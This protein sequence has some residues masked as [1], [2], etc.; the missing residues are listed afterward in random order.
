MVCPSPPFAWR[1]KGHTGP[2]FGSGKSSPTP[3]DERVHSKS[4][5][6]TDV[7]MGPRFRRNGYIE[8][9]LSLELGVG[10]NRIDTQLHS[11]YPSDMFFR[12]SLPLALLMLI[13]PQVKASVIEIISGF[14][15]S[16]GESI[17]SRIQIT[18]PGSVTLF[19]IFEAGV[20]SRNACSPS[21]L[22]SP[23]NPVPFAC[24]GTAS[25]EVD[26]SGPA[27]VLAQI[28]ENYSFTCMGPSSATNFC[29][30]SDDLVGY[31]VLCNGVETVAPR[32]GLNPSPNCALTGLPAGYY[33][34]NGIQDQHIQADANAMTNAYD[35]YI[36][37][38]L[39]GD[40]VPTP[41]P[42]EGAFAVLLVAA[43]LEFRSKR[44][45]NPQIK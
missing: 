13:S 9:N 39:I 24:S 5:S 29:F 34:L 31:D 23:D 26:F 32:G 14:P 45:S 7:S 10:G 40:V 41:E 2:N 44:M 43:L 4:A 33:T 1:R 12:R 11:L 37:V 38:A 25:G 6:G 16:S 22:L 3:N 19:A 21:P 27:G 8:A 28:S 18:D 35:P 42:A 17:G 30:E 36:E 20:D 15:S